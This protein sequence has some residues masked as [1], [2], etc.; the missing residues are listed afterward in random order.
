MERSNVWTGLIKVHQVPENTL[1]VTDLLSES[2]YT[3]L[4]LEH[5]LL[6]DVRFSFNTLLQSK[7]APRLLMM[8]CDTNQ[9]LNVETKQILKSLFNT[10][11]QNQCVK[12]Y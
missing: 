12:L 4:T 6:V 3:I 7:K 5:M 10:L 9:L 8:W 1:S 11:R 2:H